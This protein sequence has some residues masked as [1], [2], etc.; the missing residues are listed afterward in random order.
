MSRENEFY[1]SSGSGRLPPPLELSPRRVPL[2]LLVAGPLQ[3]EGGG[4]ADKVEAEHLRHLQED[5]RQRWGETELP[6]FDG[7]VAEGFP[8]RAKGRDRLEVRDRADTE[9]GQWQESFVEIFFWKSLYF[10]VTKIYD[11]RAKEWVNIQCLQA[12]ILSA[13]SWL[14]CTRCS[15]AWLDLILIL[16]LK[17]S[18]FILAF[19]I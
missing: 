4:S 19:V 17:R 18:F 10:E 5:K 1:L 2:L 14:H 12:R 3:G 11:H 15:Q 8:L 7:L 6:W 13:Y 9:H 16:L